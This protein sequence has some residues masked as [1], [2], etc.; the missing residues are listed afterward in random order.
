M[1]PPDADLA[2]RFDSAMKIAEMMEPKYSQVERRKALPR[3]PDTPPRQQSYERP[4]EFEGTWP[5]NTRARYFPVYE[6]GSFAIASGG[7]TPTILPPRFPPSGPRS[8]TQ[9]AVLITSRL[10]SMTTI[11]PPASMR[12]RKAAS[13]LL[14]SSKCNPVVGSSKM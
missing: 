11:E 7:P 1:N 6:P 12:R 3:L 9:S 8:M 2:C 14:T 13:S 4:L 10:C 5:F